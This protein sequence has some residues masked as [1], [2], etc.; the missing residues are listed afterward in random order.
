MQTCRHCQAHQLNG[1]IF[2]PECGAS[3]LPE[4]GDGP[5]RQTRETTPKREQASA[6]LSFEGTTLRLLLPDCPHAI[7]LRDAA[8]YLIGRRCTITEG[9]PLVDLTPYRAVELGVSRRHAMIKYVGDHFIIEDLMSANGTFI[10]GRRLAPHQAVPLA[11]GDE[12][13]FSLMVVQ[14]Q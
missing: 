6:K 10:N 13:R 2:C 12:V 14:C 4:P 8:E 7:E 9:L 11:P 3:M 1:T 5:G